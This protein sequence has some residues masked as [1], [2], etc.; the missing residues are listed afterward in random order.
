M[1]MLSDRLNNLL[2]ENKI[3]MYRLAKDFQCSKTT[4]T[5]WCDGRNEPKAT[6]IIKL[7]TYFNVS[8]DYLLG[9]EDE[10]GTK[11]YINNS[12]NNF[13]NSGNFKL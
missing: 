8:S 4:I 11:T 5:N 1:G 10:T 3:T 7:A 9:L 6:E 13:N 12:F 2:K